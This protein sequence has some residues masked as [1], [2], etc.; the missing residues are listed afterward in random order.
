[1]T[2]SY[3]IGFFGDFTTGENY[4][5]KY[6]LSERVNILRQN[7]YEYLFEKVAPILNRFDMNILNLETPLTSVK[8]SSLTHKKTVLHW[9]DKNIVPNL[10]NKYNVKAVSLGNN[11]ALDYD[12]AGLVETLN[13]L[14][15]NNICYFGAGLNLNSAQMPFVKRITLNE[16]YVNL[17]VIGGF[18]YKKDYDED[19]RFYADTNKEGVF[20]LNDKSAIEL[21]KSIKENDKNSVIVVFPHFGFDL[22]KTTDLQ[23]QYAHS[24]ID[25]GADYVVGHGPHM[26]NSIEKYKG[27]I[28]LYGIGNFIFPANFKGKVL[29]YNMAVGMEFFEGSATLDSKLYIYPTY[30]DNQSF[31]PQTRPLKGEELDEFINLL[32]EDVEDLRD[33]LKTEVVEDIIR[34]E[35]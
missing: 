17:Y 29:P 9:A 22:M 13:A 5:G 20:M 12:K 28:I 3:S 11:H 32:V 2:E 6:D 15:D 7:G 16:K 19:F 26:M 1:M 21:I 23:I 18:K 27:K 35:V 25:S 31:T 14:S 8:T 33:S 34:I 10:L 24:F 30:M 4:Q